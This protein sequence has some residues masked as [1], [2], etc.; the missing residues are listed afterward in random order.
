MSEAPIQERLA[1]LDS[2]A[3]AWWRAFNIH[4]RLLGQGVEHDRS[5]VHRVALNIA[6]LPL[7]RGIVTG[8]VTDAACREAFDGCLSAARSNAAYL[9]DAKMRRDAV[10]VGLHSGFGYE[11]NALLALNRKHSNTWFAIPAMSRC[12]SGLYNRQ[13]THDLLVIHQKYGSTQ[14]ATPVEIKAKASMRDRRRYKALLVRG[15]MHLSAPGKYK[16]EDT[17]NA[18]ASVYDGVASEE[19]ARV[20]DNATEKFTSMIRDY[21][22]GQVLGSAANTAAVTVFRDSA[23]V[24]A[25][26]PGLATVV[27]AA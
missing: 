25:H 9:K 15:R 4:S 11:C 7:L 13:D 12:D 10:A 27:L 20:A 16:P 14:S 24:R 1:M 2:A 21:Y 18:I 3:D 17:L 5:Q 19:D 26:H 6:V 8:D 22:A 23:Q